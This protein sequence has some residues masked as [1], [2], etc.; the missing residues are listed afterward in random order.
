MELFNKDSDYATRP[1]QYCILADSIS[2]SV[3]NFYNDELVLSYN[4]NFSLDSKPVP[5]FDNDYVFFINPNVFDMNSKKETKFMG[6]YVR[7]RM[8]LK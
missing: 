1:P 6:I 3:Y 8:R 4:K 5:L 2:V 7:S